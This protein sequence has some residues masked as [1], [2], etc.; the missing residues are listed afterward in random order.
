MNNALGFGAP[1]AAIFVGGS[2]SKSQSFMHRLLSSPSGPSGPSGTASGWGWDCALAA[3][4]VVGI[5]VSGCGVDTNGLFDDGARDAG[6]TGPFNDGVD[7]GGNVESGT[8]PY[9]PPDETRDAAVTADATT[10]GAPGGGVDASADAKP[11]AGPLNACDADGDGHKSFACGG[12]DCCDLDSNVYPR[13]S[14]GWFDGVNRCGR[15]DYDCDGMVYL[16][17][18]SVQC[19]VI[20]D[21]CGGEGFVT[22]PVCGATGS[23]E[24]CTR[25]SG[26]CAPDPATAYP[27]IQ[28]CH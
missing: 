25:A 24:A 14:P 5:C 6:A 23:W 26:A 27:A 7:A 18:S 28:E 1:F 22:T 20:N 16:R 17:F 15:Y 9:T 12:D 4:G 21:V 2:V 19:S 11:E 8:R 10:P 13:S 3:A